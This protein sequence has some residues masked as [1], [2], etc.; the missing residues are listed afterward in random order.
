MTADEDKV[1]GNENR[2]HEPQFIGR[3][4]DKEV[5]ITM[6]SGEKINGV[7]LKYNRYELLFKEDDSQFFESENPVPIVLMKN[8]IQKIAVRG[9][10][11]P[12]EKKATEEPAVS[13]GEA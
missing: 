10:E 8:Y 7:I 13:T 1:K 6:H 5:T 4:K 3:L 12:F 9:N 11:N 2:I